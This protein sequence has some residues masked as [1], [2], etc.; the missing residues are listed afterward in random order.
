MIENGNKGQEQSGAGENVKQVH[1]YVVGPGGSTVTPFGDW[2]EAFDSPIDQDMPVPTY[3]RILRMAG[4]DP[5][6]EEIMSHYDPTKKLMLIVEMRVDGHT[7]A[8]VEL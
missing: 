1:R 2:P 4:F 5:R 8:W 3:D 6:D 7:F